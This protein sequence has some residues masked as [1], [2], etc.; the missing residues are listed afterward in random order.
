MTILGVT[1]PAKLFVV[2]VITEAP[3][4]TRPTKWKD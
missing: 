2:D 3:K 1:N 4:K